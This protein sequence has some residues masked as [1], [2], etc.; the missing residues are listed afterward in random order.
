[1]ILF[2][3]FDKLTFNRYNC[4]FRQFSLGMRQAY[5]VILFANTL[6]KF[7]ILLSKHNAYFYRSFDDCNFLGPNYSVSNFEI[8]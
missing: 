2:W 4:L 8:I 3:N 5:F 7:E 1:M 6:R